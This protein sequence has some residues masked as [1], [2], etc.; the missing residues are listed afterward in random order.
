[1]SVS[2]LPRNAETQAREGAP[3]REGP[4]RRYSGA[5]YADV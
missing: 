3:A 5:V 4:E 1:M 2:E